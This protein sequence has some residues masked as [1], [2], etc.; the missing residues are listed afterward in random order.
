[1]PIERRTATEGVE[2]R[3]EGDTLTAIGYAAIFDRLSGNLLGD[4]PHDLGRA[5]AQ[6]A[7]LADRHDR[8]LG[9]GHGFEHVPCA[10]EQRIVAARGRHG[11]G[12]GGGGL[13]GH[14]RAPWRRG[15]QFAPGCWRARLCSSA[16]R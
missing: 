9:I 15:Y 16:S 6:D 10:G 1:M 11:V 2:L 7:E 3:E 14:R 5:I 12:G 4:A 13:D 8:D